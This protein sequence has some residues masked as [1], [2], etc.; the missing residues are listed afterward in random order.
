MSRRIVVAF[1]SGIIMAMFFLT[2]SFLIIS[3][4]ERIDIVKSKLKMNNETVLRYLAQE[5]VEKLSLLTNTTDQVRVTLIDVDGQVLF[6]SA[7]T[8]KLENHFNREEVQEALNEGEGTA[9]RVS[10]SLG[11][12]MVYY[13][14]RL[15]DGRVLRSSIRSETLNL[16][17]DFA[18]YMFITFLVVLGLSIF[19]AR[20]IVD[21]LL[22]PILE[23]T[24]ATER[25]AAGEY[26]RR[27][28]VRRDKELEQ[29]SLNFNNM[30]ERLENTFLENR[31]K[32][33]R[34]EAILKSMNAGV[35]AY[36][37]H[38]QIIM[39]NPFCKELF[40]IYED[41]IGKNVHEVHEIR[42]L[43][44]QLESAEE[45]LEIQLEEPMKKDVRVKSAVIYGERLSVVGTVIVLEDVTDLKKL[46]KMRS[47]FVANVSHELKTPLTSIK[48]FAE[49]LKY[50]GDE[51]TRNKFLDIIND[52]SERLTR[53]INDILTLSSIEQVRSQKHEAID[54]G[55]ETD[56]IYSLLV[57]KAEGRKISLVLEKRKSVI[58][59][60]DEDHYKQLLLNLVD[61][62]IKYTKEGGEVRI[63]LDQEEEDFV[64]SVSDTGIG[65]PEKHLSRIFERFYRVDKARD[66]AMGGTGLGLA[67]VK[68]IVLSMGGDIDV[69]SVLQK[70]TTFLVHL[71]LG[72]KREEN[73]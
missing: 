69:Q 8:S 17:G 24:Y 10:S 28:R 45:V 6:D 11:I 18:V 61:N 37:H 22:E 7:G 47:Q 46:E 12:P 42:T 20:K 41:V 23:M 31:D 55:Y 2:S 62:A 33:N 32:Q 3:N 40:G 52:E 35:F 54:V 73:E 27:V 14:T 56:K 30:A 67:I 71:P 49:T 60:G 5:E 48:G 68:H 19:V 25:I 36:D 38:G 1:L 58:L 63:V 4:L 64:L 43:L 72:I 39:I 15:E 66:R 44:Y 13:A 70:G 57:P 65:I 51:A 21:Y 26:A 53:L 50:V 29:L 16:G 59:W 34:L 9:L